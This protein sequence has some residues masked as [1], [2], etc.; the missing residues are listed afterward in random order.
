MSTQKRKTCPR[1]DWESPVWLKILEA[2]EPLNRAR[3]QYRGSA[4][5]GLDYARLDAALAKSISVLASARAIC[6][7]DGNLANPAFDDGDVWDLDDE[8]TLP[9][10]GDVQARKGGRS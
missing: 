8:I 5:L 9:D 1:S 6:I 2:F 7:T 4:A 3:Q 10:L